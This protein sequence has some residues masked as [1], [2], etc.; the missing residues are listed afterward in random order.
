MTDSLAHG[1]R[2]NRLLAA[3]PPEMLVQMEDDLQQISL[4]RGMVLLEPGDAVNNIYFPQTGLISLLIVTKDGGTV[5]AAT[6]G[7]E[8]G[9]GLQRGYGPRRSFT[10][11]TA[12]IGGR[13]SAIGAKRFEQLVSDQPALRD[14]IG[15]YTEVALAEAHQLA[16][17]N[18]TH[19][20]TSRLARWL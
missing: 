2:D 17:C 9:V 7:R 1:H 6:V 8:G 18:A 11:A 15:S 19:D 12:Q 14:M 5:E 20:A 16:A 3:L 13:F 10:R 4:P